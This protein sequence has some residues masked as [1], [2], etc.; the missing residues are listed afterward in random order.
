MKRISLCA[1]VAGCA[2][3]SS[4]GAVVHDAGLDLM[5]NAR[6]ANVYTNRYGGVWSFMKASFTP[7]T[8]KKTYVTGKDR[9]LLPSVRTYGA[10]DDFTVARGP[11]E[12]ASA[13]PVIA[14]NPSPNA[15]MVRLSNNANGYF[16][17]Q[18]G[19]ISIHPGDKL[20]AVSCALPCRATAAT[21]SRPSSGTRTRVLSAW[22]R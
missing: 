2:V 11:A 19:Q 5:M 14:V 7:D 4:C 22:W 12:G 17:G 1:L 21:R 6:S 16:A 8:T 9:T 10:V 3:A 18:P 13:N 15:D 20:S